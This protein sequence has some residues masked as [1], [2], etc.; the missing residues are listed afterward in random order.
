MAIEFAYRQVSKRSVFWVRA[1]NYQ[2]LVQ[3][4]QK[5]AEMF[6]VKASTDNIVPAVKR[7]LRDEAGHD[8]VM[9]FDNGDEISLIPEFLP[10]GTNGAILTSTRDPRLGYNIATCAIAVNV[11]ERE[12]GVQ[13]LQHR[14]NL[15]DATHAGALVDLLGA[16]PSAI[17]Q[18]AVYIRERRISVQ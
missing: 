18:A 3:E 11:L 10:T 8:W 2:V 1:D 4:F 9:V 5:L 17:E 13:M 15:K 14:A 16:L 12:I 7:W 6:N